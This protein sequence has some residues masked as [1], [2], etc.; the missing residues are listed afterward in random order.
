MEKEN[1]TKI[2]INFLQYIILIYH[3]A[4]S[5]ASPSQS[6]KILLVSQKC[7]IFFSLLLFQLCD[8]KSCRSEPLCF[9]FALVLYNGKWL[10]FCIAL[11][12]AIALPTIEREIKERSK[13]II[14][15]MKQRISRAITGQGE[16]NY[17]YRN[18]E[19]IND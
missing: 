6:T 16:M 17:Y 2:P 15:K 18:I 12:I 10:L 13:E 14:T 4:P 9:V 11:L 7:K 1:V 19:K 8:S 5:Y 3:P